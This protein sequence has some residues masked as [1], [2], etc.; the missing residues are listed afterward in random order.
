MLR[1]FFAALF[2][3]I[4][5][6]AGV[7]AHAADFQKGLDAAKAGD[8]ATALKEW[9]PLA[10]QG[11][12]DAQFNLGIMYANGE[13]VPKDDVEAARWW[14]LAAEQGHARAQFNLGIMY[15][16]GEGVLK[17]MVF[18]HMW[19]NIAGANGSDSAPENRDIVESRM[20]SE[21]IAEA[22]QRARVCMSSGYSD[23]G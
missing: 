4:I 23:C 13:G 22:T 14:R 20:T 12:A 3:I 5:A 21:Q 8:Y 2:A 11:D 15:A 17:D 18:A 16:N 1:I 7:V 19:L 10:E 6:F 9:Q